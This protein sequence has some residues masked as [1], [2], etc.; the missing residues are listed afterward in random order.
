MIRKTYTFLHFTTL[1]VTF[2]STVLFF[3]LFQKDVVEYLAQKYLKE[4]DVKYKHVEGTLF[5]GVL[6]KGVKY[7]N[8]VEIEELRVEY[9]LLMLI[10]PAPRLKYISAAG[11]YVDADRL[12]EIQSEGESSLF[13][14]N[15][16]KLSINRA[17]IKYKEEI[18]SLNLVGSD[19]NLRD[20]IDIQ[21]IALQAYTP[22]A[23]I[24]LEGNVK[25][26]RV[27]GKSTDLLSEKLHH[28]YLDFLIYT[29]NELEVIFDMSTKKAEFKTSLKSAVFKD[30]KSVLLNN[31]NLNIIYNF[32]DDFF[33]LLSDYA[34]LYEGNEVSLEQKSMIMFDGKIDSEIKAKILK[35]EM[36]LPFESFTVKIK[37]DDNITEA[38]F[39]AEDITLNVQTKDF[40]TFLLKAQSIYA[41]L[42]AKLKTEDNVFTL[43]GELYLKSDAPYLKEYNLQRFSKLNLFISRT[44]EKTEANISADIFSLN[45]FQDE[46]GV[47]GVGKA[48]SSKFDIKGNLNEKYL[49]IESN[50]KS[51]KMLLSELQLGMT[52]DRVFFDASAGIKAEISFKE[53]VEVNARV[54]IPWYKLELDS[55]NTY[56]GRD[57]F[58]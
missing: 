44:K 1:F 24:Y 54:D 6:L 39:D 14:L 37:R 2:I 5:D 19:I 25:A 49:K 28:E 3:V 9:N 45:L 52:D 33:T 7:K 30:I 50:I 8:S 15:I 18:Y 34:L 31:L 56:T 4:Y 16:S 57:A 38:V 11:V 55:K 51:L 43:L 40:K 58:F 23:R 36:G 27:R 46:K 29:P 12:L 22:Y 53:R 48:G 47:T 10:N 17:K 35:D 13:A 32:N 41:D 20:K 42:D 26:N 21:K